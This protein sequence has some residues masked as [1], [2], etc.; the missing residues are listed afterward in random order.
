VKNNE[1]II[2]AE[3]ERREREREREREGG[4]GGRRRAH[5]TVG[6]SIPRL[7]AIMIDV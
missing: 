6:G 7:R 4:E 3:L 5:A 2:A 1:E